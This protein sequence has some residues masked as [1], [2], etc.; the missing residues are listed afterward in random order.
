MGISCRNL[1]GSLPR[2]REFRYKNKGTGVK[3]G[4]YIRRFDGL[5]ESG[6][7]RQ[8]CKG[9]ASLPSQE[10]L[11]LATRVGLSQGST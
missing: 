2:I 10:S 4:H 3:P 9:C 8:D 11:S 1:R 7:S 6:Y 5:S